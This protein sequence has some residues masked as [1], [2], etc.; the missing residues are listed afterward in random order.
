M[1]A[2]LV[3]TDGLVD[4]KTIGDDVIKPLVSQRGLLKRRI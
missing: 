3:Y 1:P 4:S 2:T